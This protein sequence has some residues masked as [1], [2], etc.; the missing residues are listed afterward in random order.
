MP[1]NWLMFL[2]LFLWKNNPPLHRSQSLLLWKLGATEKDVLNWYK[3]Q[4]SLST[5]CSFISSPK[6]SSYDS[7]LQSHFMSLSVIT[8]TFSADTIRACQTSWLL[9]QI[10]PTGKLTLWEQ[11]LVHSLEHLSEHLQATLHLVGPANICWV[12]FHTFSSNVFLYMVQCL[13]L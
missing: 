8:M 11:D 5:I 6:V 1:N 2:L 9:Q 7:G 3:K 12:F 10:S 4:S 13:L